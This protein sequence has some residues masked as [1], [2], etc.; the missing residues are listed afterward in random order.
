MTEMPT[1]NPN[2]TP[3]P[4][5]PMTAAPGS[6][7]HLLA[8][9][10]YLGSVALIP[11]LLIF[12]LKYQDSPFLRFHSIQAMALLVL[13]LLFGVTAQVGALV[14]GVMSLLPFLN[15]IAGVMSTIFLLAGSGL[16]LAFVA[17]W[18][19]L[20]IRAFQG[21]SMDI[22]VVAPLIREKLMNV[23]AKAASQPQESPGVDATP[24]GGVRD[25]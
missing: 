6:D 17:Y 15:I 7:D 20:S 12:I 23:G 1:D 9:I 22:P 19:I 4:A 16:M 10:A 13:L 18:L 8:G 5:S 2:Q 14:L 25:E 3:P 24:E 21:Q 11:P